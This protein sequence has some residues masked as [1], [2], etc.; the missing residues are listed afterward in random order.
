MTNELITPIPFPK[1]SHY[2][3]AVNF[4]LNNIHK[5][6][7]Y[8]NSRNE[9]IYTN[10]QFTEI[11]G[12]TFADVRG[13][14]PKVLQSGIQGRSFYEEMKETINET[15]R[16]KGRLW[17]RT[18]HGDIY[19]QELEIYA[20]R[21]EEGQIEHFIGFLSKI[22]G[23]DS[24]SLTDKQDEEYYDSLTNLPNRI[25]FEKRLHSSL[26]LL[27]KKDKQLTVIF[28]QVQNFHE[29]NEK[30]GLL[31]GNILLK[32]IAKRMEK[33]VPINSMVSRWNGT[34]F[35]CVIEGFKHKK[36]IEKKVITYVKVLTAPYIINGISIDIT[37]R[38]GISMYHTEREQKKIS[39]STLLKNAKKA[40]VQAKKQD[41]MYC[42][43]D[44][45]MGL[46]G[47]LIVMEEEIVR[48]IKEKEFTL[49]YQ[50]LLK[51]DTGQL[52]GFEALIRWNHPQE[53][54]IAPGNFI[55]L[56]EK[57]GL[58]NDIGEF[59]F[60]EACKQQVLWRKAGYGDL[61]VSI[62]LSMSQFKDNFLVEYI[63]HVLRDTGANPHYISIE[64]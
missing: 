22:S 17:N 21:N 49:F 53:G 56:A 57:T 6:V 18:K 38:S 40:L 23:H 31:F 34:T 25:L 26:Q 4:V 59:V 54:L 2:D 28:F 37:V 58:I 1:T 20:F 30:F 48:A 64:L 42:F 41:K 9:I 19:L 13:Q 52:K 61:L 16:W 10:K 33:N 8:T 3:D 35:A 12:Y 47:H 44:R 45:S 11:T 62:N 50:P 24:L 15:N 7:I 32:R 51:A 55:P 46:N 43:Y 60:K 36:D 39:V 29:V 14:S 5:G 27:S 63:T